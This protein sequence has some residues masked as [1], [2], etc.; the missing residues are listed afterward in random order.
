[1][2]IGVGSHCNSTVLGCGLVGYVRYHRGFVANLCHLESS[3]SLTRNGPSS[4]ADS[5][6]V[7]FICN[8]SRDYQSWTNG[9]WTTRSRRFKADN[10]SCQWWCPA[11]S[12]VRD[13]AY[14]GFRSRGNRDVQRQECRHD[15][16]SGRRP[17]HDYTGKI[18][19]VEQ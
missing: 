15:E 7:Q 14:R 3:I 16:I 9:Y 1:M 10:T 2:V 5:Q 18:S 19:P 6:R 11:T 17:G 4:M 13:S 8:R 12:V